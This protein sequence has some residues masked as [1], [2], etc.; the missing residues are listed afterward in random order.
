MNPSGRS[1]GSFLI[2]TA[3]PSYD[4]GKSGVQIIDR[5]YSCGYSSGIFLAE[6]PDSLFI[7]CGER[8]TKTKC[9]CKCRAY[10]LNRKKL[11]GIFNNSIDQIVSKTD[12]WQS[13]CQ[14]VWRLL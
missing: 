4:S 14:P 12:G 8:R 7:L 9:D 13:F 10:F 5:T 6:A 11:G 3:F 1:S 2:L